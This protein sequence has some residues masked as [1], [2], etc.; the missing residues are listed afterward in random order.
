ME[1]LRSFI[2]G[3]VGPDRFRVEEVLGGGFVRLNVSEAQRRQAKQ[4]I[5]SVEDI[6]IEML[7]NARDANARHI[8]VATVREGDL[9]R[10][11]FIDDGD[12]IP[13]DMHK[14]VFDARV[15]S[16]LESFHDDEWGVHGRGMALYSVRQNAERAEVVASGP[17]LGTSIAVD[18]DCTKLPERRDQSTWPNVGRDEDGRLRTSSGPHNI[19]RT[20]LE[21]ALCERGVDVHLGSPLEI[22][23]LLYADDPAGLGLQRLLSSDPGGLPVCSRLKPAGDAR[24]LAEASRSIGLDISERSAYRIIASEVFPPP[25]VVVQSRT[26]RARR[27]PSG[28]A[29]LMK[30]QRCLHVSKEDSQALAHAL[31]E[32]FEGFARQYYLDYDIPTVSIRGT[33]IN[34]TFT[35]SLDD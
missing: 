1:D 9:R 14:R 21:F 20:V 27:E 4:D 11:V 35:V 6:V 8:Y 16:K 34:I 33:T 18:V 10:L 28:C 23:A 5:R 2:E 22:A 24:S 13:A 7:R 30:E 32:A 29:D 25:S 19:V 12:G 17:G 3:R 26:N 31:A 15:T